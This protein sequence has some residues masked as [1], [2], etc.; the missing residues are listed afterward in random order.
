[1]NSGRWC[2]QS[3]LS[4][5]GSHVTIIHDALKFTVRAVQT[6]SLES[7]LLVTSGGHHLRPVHTDHTYWS[8]YGRRK[9]AVRFLLDCFRFYSHISKY[10]QMDCLAVHIC[11]MLIQRL[12]YDE[13][14]SISVRSFTVVMREK[15]TCV[16]W[17]EISRNFKFV[18]VFK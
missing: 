3:C 10:W 9:Q 6:C 2:F 8:M 18:V 15:Y 17:K 1:M 12:N 4:V 11:R 16:V 13:K 7:P 5:Q 14:V